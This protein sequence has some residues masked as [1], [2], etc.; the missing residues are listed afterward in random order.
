SGH[1]TASMSLAFAAVLV[2][3]RLLRPAVA[4]AGAL[5]TL[6]VSESILLLAW[7]FPTDVIGGY[8]LAMSFACV[9][10]SA[11]RAA[12]ARWPE[13]SGREA[14]LRVLREPDSRAVAA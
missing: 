6:A 5:F 10:V 9:I 3:P 4:V 11:L 13:R 8:L 2:A 14:A 1:A 7:H 12:D